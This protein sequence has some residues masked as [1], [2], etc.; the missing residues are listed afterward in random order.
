M[1]IRS[2]FIVNKIVFF[3]YVFSVK[4]YSIRLFGDL[5]QSDLSVYN[6]VSLNYWF[7]LPNMLYSKFI[8]LV[9]FI[10]FYFSYK[11]VIFNY[12]VTQEPKIYEF[13]HII[14]EITVKSKCG[15]FC[16]LFELCTTSYNKFSFNFIGNLL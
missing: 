4:M 6:N 2:R 11:I 14:F 16:H 7:I 15:L 10:L 9:F 8:C 13:L 5:W 12:Y 1:I 3:F